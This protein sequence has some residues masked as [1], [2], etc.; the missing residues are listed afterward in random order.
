MHGLQPP[1][2]QE[3]LGVSEIFILVWGVVL[4]GVSQGFEWK[5]KIMLS[6]YKK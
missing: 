4:F 3:V 5:F 2:A 6:Q 1:P